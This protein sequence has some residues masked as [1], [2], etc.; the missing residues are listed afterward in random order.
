MRKGTTTIGMRFNDFVLLASDRRATAGYYIAHKRV[1]KIVKVTD[2]M[3]LTVAGLV[4]DAQ[5]LAD[6][7]AKH[8]ILYQYRTGNKLS[9]EAAANY[10]S[11]ILHSS[12]FY[13]YIVQLLIGGY[14][15]K[16]RLYSLDWYGTLTEE[17]IVATG[18][19]SPI[20]IGLLED[21][22]RDDLE[23]DEAVKLARRAITSS[24]RRDSFTGNGVDI[25]VIGKDYIKEYNF[26]IS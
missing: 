6:Y 26:E 16:P 24:I 18:S 2:Y 3:A 1:K 9:V 19:G 14:D 20:A 5:M 4:A 7:L 12:R 11:I 8:A 22:Y 23:V 10:L 13:P 15:T 25:I 21:Q 17:K